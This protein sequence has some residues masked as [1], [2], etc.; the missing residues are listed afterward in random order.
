MM[1]WGLRADRRIHWY[2]S[3][4]ALGSNILVSVNEDGRI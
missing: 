2:F 4:I 1:Q 3:W